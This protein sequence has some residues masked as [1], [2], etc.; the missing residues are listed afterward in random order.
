VL[1]YAKNLRRQ[2]RA[3]HCDCCEHPRHLP[4]AVAMPEEGKK[5]SPHFGERALALSL[6]QIKLAG[7]G[8]L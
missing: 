6:M 7:L 2:S 4:Q 3:S 1:V 5:T 8:G